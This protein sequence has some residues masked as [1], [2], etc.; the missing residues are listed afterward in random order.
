MNLSAAQHAKSIDEMLRRRPALRA[1]P[2][3]RRSLAPALARRI[4]RSAEPSLFH[5]C[6]AVHMHFAEYSG[7]LHR[8]ES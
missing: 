7:A 3:A 2:T 5:R 6:L 1:A 4:R 8:S